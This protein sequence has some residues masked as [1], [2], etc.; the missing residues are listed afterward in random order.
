[1]YQMPCRDI[2][3]IEDSLDFVLPNT[4]VYETDDTYVSSP[5]VKYIEVYVIGGGGS[6]G[7]GGVGLSGGCG[8]GA[9]TPSVGFYAPGTYSITIGTGRSG[10][11]IGVSGL[12][13]RV[14]TFGSGLLIS[15]GGGGGAGYDATFPYYAGAVGAPHASAMY[16]LGSEPGQVGENDN[17]GGCGGSN[18]FGTGGRAAYNQNVAVA[19]D[20]GTGYGS[21]GAGG[22]QEAAGGAGA[23]GAIIIIEHF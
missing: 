14:S 19:G 23:N 6:G 9:A 22:S 16:T 10:G 11:A 12:N 8:G 13:G 18:Y 17:Q 15:N 5:N 3:G 4:I 20:P 21:G 2:S 7:G 1:M